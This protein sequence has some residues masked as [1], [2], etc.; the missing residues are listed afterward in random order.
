MPL[1]PGG[2]PSERNVTVARDFPDAPIPPRAGGTEDPVNRGSLLGSGLGVAESKVHEGPVSVTGR[3]RGA[4]TK[5]L[6]PHRARLELRGAALGIGCVNGEQV[7]P[8]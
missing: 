1:A 2:V 6:N 8:Y 4:G 7:H 3:Q 5:R